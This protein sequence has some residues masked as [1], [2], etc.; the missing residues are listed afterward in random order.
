MKI[1][2]FTQLIILS[3]LLL[4]VSCDTFKC[5]EGSGRIDRAYRG[6]SNFNGVRMEG[7][8]DVFIEQNDN[9]EYSVEVEADKNFLPYISTEVYSNILEIK[10]VNNRCL[11][12]DRVAV[13]VTLPEL[14][15]VQLTGSGYI[16]AKCNN[17]YNDKMNISHSGSGEISVLGINCVET[18]TFL[19]G[20]GII[21]LSGVTSIH[22]VYLSGSGYISAFPLDTEESY[23]KMSGSGAMYLFAYNYLDAVI[24]GSGNVFY[25]GN[26]E[27]HFTITG[28]GNIFNRN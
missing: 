18:E 25:Q 7:D 22:N 17:L 1:N 10:T 3:V 27:L 8:F 6:F 28:S 19:S 21:K 2:G 16:E 9:N 13:Y 4:M 14:L 12:G 20:S 11:N 26:P 24:T 5:I 23:A 15:Y